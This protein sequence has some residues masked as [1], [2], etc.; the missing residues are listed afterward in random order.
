MATA[1]APSI[2]GWR[3]YTLAMFVPI[4][5]REVWVAIMATVTT[6]SLLST[7]STMNRLW[8][9]PSSARRARSTASR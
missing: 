7:L 8:N 3:R 2:T 5:S 4:S 1:A 6:P 9:P